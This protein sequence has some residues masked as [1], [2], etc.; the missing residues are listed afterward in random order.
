MY[1]IFLIMALLFNCW[2]MFCVVPLLDYF[3][4]TATI[5]MNSIILLLIMY[6]LDN[7]LK[8]EIGHPGNAYYISNQDRLRSI[9]SLLAGIGSLCATV[10]M[11]NSVNEIGQHDPLKSKSPLFIAL[12]LLIN[13]IAVYVSIS[14]M[15]ILRMHIPDMHL[16]DRS[17]VDG[18]IKGNADN[19]QEKIVIKSTSE[20]IKMKIEDQGVWNEQ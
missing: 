1:P 4:F 12:F 17:I 13:F 19:T 10:A 20:K 9:V 3:L 5:V 6:R 14:V 8:M 11:L 7:P 18:A 16:F 2:L 15:Q